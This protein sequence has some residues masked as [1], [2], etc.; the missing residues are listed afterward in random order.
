MLTIPIVAIALFGL[1][2]IIFVFV[3]SGTF[4]G[5][6]NKDKITSASKCMLLGIPVVIL[7]DMLVAIAVYASSNHISEHMR[8]NLLESIRGYNPEQGNM[9]NYLQEQFH[10]CGVNSYLD[11]TQSTVLNKT[12]AVPDSCC[13]FSDMVSLT[14]LIFSHSEVESL[15]VNL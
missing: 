1:V 13:V 11:W 15:K 3:S 4:L 2:L 12:H 7:L 8:D 5:Q 14:N 10:C 9:W 6:R